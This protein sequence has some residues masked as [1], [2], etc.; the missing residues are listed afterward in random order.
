MAKENYLFQED[1]TA[2]FLWFFNLHCRIAKTLYPNVDTKGSKGFPQYSDKTW[3]VFGKCSHFEKS[4]LSDRK[5]HQSAS[6]HHL[7]ILFHLF[8]CCTSYFFPSHFLD[9]TLFIRFQKCFPNSIFSKHKKKHSRLV[10]AG[11]APAQ[12]MGLSWGTSPLWAFT[13]AFYI[14]QR[15]WIMQRSQET[16]VCLQFAKIIDSHLRLMAGTVLD[17]G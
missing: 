17:K 11:K 3:C 8:H 12:S 6:L 10:E 5:M 9:W 2:F 13:E 14:L 4:V 1:Q 16:S 15:C 7:W